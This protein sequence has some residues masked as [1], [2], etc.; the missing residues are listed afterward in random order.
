[1]L[2][3]LAPVD[4][5]S[6]LFRRMH[7]YCVEARNQSGAITFIS[8]YVKA[9]HSSYLAANRGSGRYAELMLYVGV[10]PDKMTAA[11]LDDLVTK[12]DD[13]CIQHGGLRYMHSKTGKD[14]ARLKKIDPNY[15]YADPAP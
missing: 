7:Q 11:V 13:L 14:P 6:Q 15:R 3:V 1:M 9:I 10:N 8:F 5:Y 4:T 12:L 2:I